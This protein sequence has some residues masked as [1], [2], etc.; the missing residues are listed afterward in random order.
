MKIELLE[1]REPFDLIFN[2]SIERFLQNYMYNHR[3][4]SKVKF[5]NVT[6]RKNKYL[7]LVYSSKTPFYLKRQ[8]SKE[9]G[10]SN[11]KIRQ[12]FQKIYCFVAIIPLVERAF[13]SPLSKI[14]LISSEIKQWL[15]LPGNN[16]IRIIDPVNG[17]S[18]VTL[19]NGFDCRFVKTDVMVRTGNPTLSTPKVLDYDEQWQWYTEELIEGIPIDRLNNDK[20]R[21][22]LLGKAVKNISDLR[23]DS[24]QEVDSLEYFSENLAKAR[25]LSEIIRDKNSQVYKR[26]IVIINALAESMKNTPTFQ[27][28]LCMTH[29]DFQAG[30]I[31]ANGDRVWLI[32]WEFSAMRT[33]F[34]DYLVLNLNARFPNLL[35]ERLP[36]YS[37]QIGLDNGINAWGFFQKGDPKTILNTFILE[38]CISKLQEINQ[39]FFD[40]LDVGLKPWINVVQA[41]LKNENEN[42]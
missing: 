21:I 9:F 18:I 25:Q 1:K 4:T 2:A 24:L 35:T 26:L 31:I 13:S 37:R 20:L 30:N 28:H 3:R 36:E 23:Q 17:V 34:Y 16:T 22:K 32:D 27:L 42:A 14:P 39:H 8:F 33:V 15:I 29:G 12:F 5:K 19:K 10:Y 38:D 41:F 6:F 40:D 7:N 11:R